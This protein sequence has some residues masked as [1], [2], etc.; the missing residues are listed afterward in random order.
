MSALQTITALYLSVP[1]VQ[2]N[3]KSKHYPM[4]RV[5]GENIPEIMVD[6]VNPMLINNPYFHVSIIC[7][8]IIISVHCLYFIFTAKL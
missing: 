4:A 6:G 2:I 7:I 1:N 5:A 8:Y 3:V